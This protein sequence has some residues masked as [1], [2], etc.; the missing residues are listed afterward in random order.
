[1]L[2]IVRYNSALTIEDLF[3]TECVG[4]ESEK[5][6]EP[7]IRDDEKVF[8]ITIEVEELCQTEKT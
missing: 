1:M 2:R 5:E 7:W 4:F 6:L 8:K 3:Q